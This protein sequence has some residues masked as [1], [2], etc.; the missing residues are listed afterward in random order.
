MLGKSREIS[1]ERCSTF[2]LNKSSITSSCRL[3]SILKVLSALLHLIR[4]V[5]SGERW[6][7]SQAP[8]G[9]DK[10]VVLFFGTLAW[11]V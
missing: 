11:K 10:D 3:R 6:R 8:G 2:S 7:V 5:R 1:R 9:R 4:L